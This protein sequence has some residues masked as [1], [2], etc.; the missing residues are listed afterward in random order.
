MRRFK[1]KASAWLKAHRWVRLFL[2]V[3]VVVAAFWFLRL[4]QS[5]GTSAPAASAPA[6][7]AR[8]ADRP[9]GKD[10]ARLA[11][12]QMEKLLSSKPAG[13]PLAEVIGTLMTDPHRPVSRADESLQSL[14]HEVSQIKD[15]TEKDED[16]MV[17][18]LDSWDEGVWEAAVWSAALDFNSKR[19]NLAYV[20]P[21]IDSFRPRVQECQPYIDLL[22]TDPSKHDATKD[23]YLAAVEDDKNI[24]V[25]FQEC[26]A[27]LSPE[28]ISQLPQ[29]M[30]D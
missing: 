10:M 2:A 6:A 17:A 16:R 27:A 14:I 15:P 9:T 28:Q 29:T 24:S 30:E 22:Y 21:V 19:N 25:Y 26:V 3:L 20:S 4:A 12:E 8:P 1:E 18:A 11:S 23:G 5:I 7:S 13:K